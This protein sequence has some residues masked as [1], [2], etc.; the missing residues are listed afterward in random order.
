MW[1][2]EG[3]SLV[4][5]LGYAFIALVWGAPVV[6]LLVGATAVGVGVRRRRNAIAA[7]EREAR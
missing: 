4:E 3:R 7:L 2:M 6:A 1:S 5:S